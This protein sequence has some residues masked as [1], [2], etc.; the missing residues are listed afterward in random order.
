V[1]VYSHVEAQGSLRKRRQKKLCSENFGFSKN[2]VIICYVTMFFIPGVGYGAAS[3]C[4]QLLTIAGNKQKKS[5]L[6]STISFS[7]SI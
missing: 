1:G 3:V 6:S 4:P 7:D 5:I 2:Q